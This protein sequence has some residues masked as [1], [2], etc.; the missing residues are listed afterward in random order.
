MS[1]AAKVACE[2]PGMNA[3]TILELMKNRDP[4]L[5]LA[6]NKIS[7]EDLGIKEPSEKEISFA[8]KESQID[9]QATVDDEVVKNKY[10]RLKKMLRSLN[11]MFADKQFS[12]N[13]YRLLYKRFA[14]SVPEAWLYQLYTKECEK[15]WRQDGEFD[16]TDFAENEKC[17]GGSE[18]QT[19]LIKADDA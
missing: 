13:A 4:Q 10:D 18:L 14:Q 6:L 8:L 5:K 11:K 2:L 12:A 16:K 9:S 3:E 1:V 19:C 15:Y 7:T 17:K